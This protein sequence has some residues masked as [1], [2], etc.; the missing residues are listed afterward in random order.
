MNVMCTLLWA[1]LNSIAKTIERGAQ[2]SCNLE[3]TASL[4]PILD[5][6]HGLLM[7]GHNFVA[8]PSARLY[9]IFIINRSRPADRVDNVSGPSL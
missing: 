5:C 8:V 3:T 2:H 6:K 7:Q 1:N 4:M 9:A